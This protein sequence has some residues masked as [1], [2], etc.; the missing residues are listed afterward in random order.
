MKITQAVMKQIEADLQKAYNEVAAK[1]GIQK[2]EVSCRRAT[3]GSFVRVSKIDMYDV[4]NAPTA[5][6]FKVTQMP[7]D[8]K[9]KAAMDYHKITSIKNAKGDTLTAYYPNSPKYCF[10]YTSARG[11]GWKCS[12]DQAR[13]R[14]N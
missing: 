12:P 14:F 8:N 4:A 1:Y 7:T 9:L 11:T 3:N 10:G 13:K 6:A 5:P 2:P